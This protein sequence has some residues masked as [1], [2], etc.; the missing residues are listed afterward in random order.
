MGS[1]ACMEP[2]PDSP[3]SGNRRP[4]GLATVANNLSLM[5]FPEGTQ[6][7]Q[8]RFLKVC[9]GKTNYSSVHPVD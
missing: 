5:R 7:E 4:H 8:F 1:K 9:T 3:N 6:V 2:M